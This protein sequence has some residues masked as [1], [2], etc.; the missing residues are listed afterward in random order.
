LKGSI[1]HPID[2][3]HLDDTEVKDAP[4]AATGLNNSLFSLISIVFSAASTSFSF[5]S[6]EAFLMVASTSIISGSS[7]REP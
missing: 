6:L 4:L 5:T 3:S 1:V 2:L 7:R